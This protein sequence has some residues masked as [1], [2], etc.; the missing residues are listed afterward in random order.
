MLGY[1]V[2]FL[3]FYYQYEDDN[4]LLKAWHFPAFNVADMAISIG[5]AML[6]VDAFRPKREQ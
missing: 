4:G 1:V 6:V 5:A 3:D 2:D